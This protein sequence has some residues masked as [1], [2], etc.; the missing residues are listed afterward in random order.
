MET[1]IGRASYVENGR[2]VLRFVR[3]VSSSSNHFKRKRRR[4][5]R[6]LKGRAYALS[7][8]GDRVDA[9]GSN[10]STS[11]ADSSYENEVDEDEDNDSFL[12][13]VPFTLNYSAG[14]VSGHVVPTLEVEDQVRTKK[15]RLEK[16]RSTIESIDDW[17]L[18]MA[19]KGKSRLQKKDIKIFE[20]DHSSD[21]YAIETLQT[22]EE[23]E[24][25]G[26]GADFVD[27]M[28][29]FLPRTDKMEPKLLDQLKK[30]FYRGCRDYEREYGA[31]S[32]K[33]RMACVGDHLYAQLS[34][35]NPHVA[36]QDYHND[37]DDNLNTS[38][39]VKHT[40]DDN[41][42]IPSLTSDLIRARRWASHHL[43]RGRGS[44][45]ELSIGSKIEVF[46]EKD[47]SWHSGIIVRYSHDT[48]NPMIMY[49]CGQLEGL[50]PCARHVRMRYLKEPS[51]TPNEKRRRKA[52][53]M[54]L[55]IRLLKFATF[56][57][58]NSKV[59]HDTVSRLS[60]EILHEDSSMSKDFFPHR[61]GQY[62]YSAS[63]EFLSSKPGGIDADSDKTVA[64]SLKVSLDQ[65][66]RA[67]ILKFTRRRLAQVW[68]NTREREDTLTA[69][70]RLMLDQ[71]G[72]SQRT[73]S[74]IIGC[75]QSTFSLWLCGTGRAY[76]EEKLYAWLKPEIEAY[77]LEL[78]ENPGRP[79]TRSVFLA[80]SVSLMSRLERSKNTDDSTTPIVSTI[81][82]SG[83]NESL[84]PES[85]EKPSAAPPAHS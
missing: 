8:R 2:R 55:G 42:D 51:M 36:P 60:T 27:S 52:L 54:N 45:H 16:K 20:P 85:A 29:T 73:I 44:R 24:D 59:R 62:H 25:E 64:S 72:I 38:E 15:R 67:N 84:L 50:D 34:R 71:I 37:E 35:L 14:L 76:V 69:N 83:T 21:L 68:I 7:N 58:V 6:T 18:R 22:R 80:S 32:S 12:E 10:G 65:Q 4:R 19:R 56:P 75:A 61:M 49:S 28:G 30:A 57:F 1:R 9:H 79:C 47:Q 53:D 74:R 11:D 70:V 48:G 43:A 5:K 17:M 78:S 41:W 40:S 26:F 81:P 33:Y 82:R 31:M 63:R 46:W 39:E 77:R 23:E 3:I 66:S 13:P